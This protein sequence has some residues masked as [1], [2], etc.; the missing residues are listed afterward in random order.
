M[1]THHQIIDY[2][3]ASREERKTMFNGMSLQKAY[4]NLAPSPIKEDEILTTDVCSRIKI[5]KNKFIELNKEGYWG[6][7]RK[8]KPKD[9]SGGIRV[10]VKTSK[11]YEILNQEAYL[12]PTHLFFEKMEK[13]QWHIGRRHFDDSFKHLYESVARKKEKRISVVNAAKIVCYMKRRKA[14]IE[15]WKTLEDLNKESGL[16]LEIDSLRHRYRKLHKLGLIQYYKVKTPGKRPIKG[17]EGSCTKLSPPTYRRRLKI[18]KEFAEIRKNAYS[19]SNISK[20]MGITKGSVSIMM[21]IGTELGLL[22]G[23]NLSLDPTNEDLIWGL[24]PNEAEKLISGKIKIPSESRL[25]NLKKELDLEEIVNFLRAEKEGISTEEI[26]NLMGISGPRVN[27]SIKVGIKMGLLHPVSIKYKDSKRTFKNYLPKEEAK[28]LINGEIYIP[29]QSRYNKV[30]SG[31]NVARRILTRT[32]M[33]A[34]ELA[35]YLGLGYHSASHLIRMVLETKLLPSA[36][37]VYVVD[38]KTVKNVISKSNAKKI[39]D[40]EIRLPSLTKFLRLQKELGHKKTIKVVRREATGVTTKELAKRLETSLTNAQKIIRH[41]EISGVLKT[42][43]Y[44][45]KG[46]GKTGYMIIPKDQ[47]EALLNGEITIPSQGEIQKILLMKGKTFS[48]KQ[49]TL[50]NKQFLLSRAKKGNQ[51]AI[52]ALCNIDS[53]YS[54]MFSKKKDEKSDFINNLP[55][56]NLTIEDEIELAARIKLGDED[57]KYELVNSN[58]RL[59]VKI[60]QNFYD[61]G[62]PTNDLISEGTL[63]MMRASETF[64]PSKGAKFSTYAAWWIKNSMQRAISNKTK[65]VRVPI[66][67]ATRIRLIKSTIN[68]LSEILRRK[69]TH[70]EISNKIGITEKKISEAIM[71]DRSIVSIHK[72]IKEDGDGTLE[73]MI[74]QDDVLNDKTT[75]KEQIET[76][77][78]I[79]RM[80]NIIPKLNESEQFIINSTFGTNG[81]KKRIES[82]LAKIINKT[83]QRVNQI[84]KEALEKL[85][86]MMEV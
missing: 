42:T 83:H 54:T 55:K 36:E 61:R 30:Q 22:H 38:E 1:Y 5:S 74:S 4:E 14:K 16:N 27:E 29:C 9:G 8:G 71:N 19:S 75:M 66:Q 72:P 34:H 25:R 62:L 85:K 58:L 2:L 68:E 84:K 12:I 37:Y 76:N 18:E 86:S 10:Y 11:F 20:K 51:K 13:E 40:G 45:Y 43:H 3:F 23:V 53:R 65:V 56:H 48:K 80:H 60:A 59:V 47:S 26:S 82:E 46:S 77:D 31:E 81:V 44:R 64:D 67:S 52:Y 21:K 7:T 35:K 79:A 33:D 70:Y 49:L 50:A 32:K 78:E 24:M 15:D 41:G 69:P 73:T 63:G 39:K 6:K 57:A 28:K 17:F